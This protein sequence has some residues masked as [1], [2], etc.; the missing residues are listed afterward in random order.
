[1]CL[2]GHSCLIGS[3][4]KGKQIIAISWKMPCCTLKYV[5]DEVIYPEKYLAGKAHRISCMY[6]YLPPEKTPLSGWR[7]WN[8]LLSWSWSHGTVV[9]CLHVQHV[10]HSSALV[11]GLASPRPFRGIGNWDSKYLI[12]AKY[13]ITFTAKIKIQSSDLSGNGGCGH[14][15]VFREPS[16]ALSLTQFSSHGVSCLLFQLGMFTLEASDGKCQQRKMFCRQC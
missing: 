6:S 15:V 7:F 4:S 14:Y 2:S 8:L 5:K 3:Q 13:V 16:L 11:V 10:E 1:M 12:W 9:S